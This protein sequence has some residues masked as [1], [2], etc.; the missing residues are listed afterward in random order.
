[1]PVTGRSPPRRGV[2]GA[3]ERGRGILSRARASAR[4]AAVATSL[5]CDLPQAPEV[6]RRAHALVARTARQRPGFH[7]FGDQQRVAPGLRSHAQRRTVDPH[8]RRAGRRGEMQRP[9][10]AADVE[11]GAS[12]EGAEVSKTKLLGQHDAPG[13]LCPESLACGLS[14]LGDRAGLGRTRREQ[15]AAPRRSCARALP[16]SSANASAGQRRKGLPALTC[17]TISS[18]ASVTPAAASTRSTRRRASAVSV[19]SAGSW[20]GSSGGMPSGA[21]RSDWFDTEC[22]GRSSRGRCTRSVYI[23]PRPAIV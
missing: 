3:A 5:W 21:S 15:D 18:A 22:R 4:S 12:H 10:V 6:S 16:S 1:M 17:I 20:T 8:D 9:A 7:R 14:D 11:R 23:Q 19:I 13:G 2:A